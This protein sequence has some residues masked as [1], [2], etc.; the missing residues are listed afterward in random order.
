MKKFISLLLVLIVI[1]CCGITVAE[2]HASATE[3][4]P[5]DLQTKDV[6]FT[7]I[8]D[9][10]EIAEAMKDIIENPDAVYGFSPNPQSTRLG[11]FA[12]ID[13]TD[14]E[15]VAQ[16]TEE[17]RAYHESMES[18][19]DILRRMIAEGASMEEIARAISAERN[20]LRLASYQNDPETLAFAKQ[21]NLQTY[22]NEEGATPEWLYEK[23]GSWITVV[24]SAFST[25]MGMDACCGLFDEY[26]QIL[27]GDISGNEADGYVL[28]N[29]A[30]GSGVSAVDGTAV[31]TGTLL[32]DTEKAALPAANATRGTIESYIESLTKV[33]ANG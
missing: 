13:W 4:Q 29:I 19:M 28:T 11:Q 2:N 8:H 30:W 27:T 17:R 32:T 3:K 14:P 10:R 25:N 23:H 33:T 20:R 16:K 7:Y 15:V 5:V 31:T 12:E 21:S 6:K 9:P 24:Q 22:G 18:M 1:L 26:Y